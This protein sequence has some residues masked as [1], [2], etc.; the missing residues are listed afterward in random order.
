LG[1]AEKYGETKQEDRKDPAASMNHGCK[2][3]SAANFSTLIG[4][5]KRINRKRIGET[6]QDVDEK[7]REEEG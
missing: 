5:L 7:F 2:S 3:P 4:L 6:G 1:H